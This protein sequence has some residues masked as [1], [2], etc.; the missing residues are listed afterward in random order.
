M[1]FNKW[2]LALAAGGVLSLGSIAQA[3]EAQNQVLTALS[4]TTLSGYVNTSAIW[5]FGTGN[6]NLPGRSYD[7]P[8]KQDSFNLDVVKLSLEK[9]LDES[10]W[11]AGYKVDLLFGPDANVFNTTS[12]W[13]AVDNQ[14]FALKQA[15]VAL[16]AP[17]GNGIDFKLGVWDTIIGYEVFDAG[18]NPNYS[19]SYGYFLEPTTYTGL[20]ASYHVTEWLSVTGGIADTSAPTINGH[21]HVESIKTYM[22]SFALTAPDSFGFLQGATL[23]GGVI[24]NGKTTAG[25][26][27]VVNWY[28]GVT[29]P[30]PLEALTVGAA[31]D[32]RG[33]SSEGSPGTAGYVPSAYA[34]A[35]G[36]Y[37]SF[38]ATEKLKLNVRGEYASGSPGS[39]PPYLD[40]DATGAAHGQKFIGVTTTLEYSLWENLLSRL[41]FRWD[42]DAS[43]GGNSF[44]GSGGGAAG[45]T[46]G[47]FEALTYA[48]GSY[49]GSG[50]HK[51]T[52]KNALSLAL[53]L[54]YK[55]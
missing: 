55:F 54:I 25:V 15:Y 52:Q 5:K 44:G 9:P 2:T 11:S 24:D 48:A 31:Y 23:Y 34:N 43:G 16:R 12:A 39:F 13:P 7:G 36:V 18:S 8:G 30:T 10:Q 42:H 4:S 32:Y 33:S 6:A 3:E 35:V 21:S 17:V 26:S 14:D 51:G 41:E 40:F 45:G 47:D 38:A 29:V 1:K 50:S 28:A 53:N 20:Q 37:A 49:N 22:G 19:R 27:D 46:P